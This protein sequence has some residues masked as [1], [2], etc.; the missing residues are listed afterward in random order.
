MLLPSIFRFASFSSFTAV[1]DIVCLYTPICTLIRYLNLKAEGYYI[2]I[3]IRFKCK[4]LS[5]INVCKLITILVDVVI[6]VRTLKCV[7]ILYNYNQT[8]LNII[9]T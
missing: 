7:H 8:A 6:Y 9:Q 1:A 4:T 3:T 2:I 5:D